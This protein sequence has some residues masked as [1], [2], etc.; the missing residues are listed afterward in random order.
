MLTAT[1]EPYVCSRGANCKFDHVTPGSVS[2]KVA[3]KNLDKVKN[4]D[5]KFAVQEAA[6][7]FRN[8]RP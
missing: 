4:G 3:L 7:R 6:D 8:F 5:L 1:G 2:K